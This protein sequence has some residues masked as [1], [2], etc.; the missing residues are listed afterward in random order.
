M[1]LKI[2]EGVVFLVVPAAA[3]ASLLFLGVITLVEIGEKHFYS[4]NKKKIYVRIE[5]YI[6]RHDILVDSASIQ[7]LKGTYFN[8][9]KR[10]Y[11]KGTNVQNPLLYADFTHLWNTAGKDAVKANEYGEIG[12]LVGNVV[13]ASGKIVQSRIGNLV[14]MIGESTS[15]LNIGNA[16]AAVGIGV[17]VGFWA[18]DRKK[19]KD[20]IREIKEK[21]ESLKLSVKELKDWQQSIENEIID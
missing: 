16:L 1:S 17:M 6:Q 12:Q 21:V 2:I 18:W 9:I 19:S 15:S 13:K 10:K 8:F 20:E 11:K 7:G 5:S 14:T 4:K 3:L